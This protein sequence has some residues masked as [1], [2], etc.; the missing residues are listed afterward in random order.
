MFAECVL[1]PDGR[2]AEITVRAKGAYRLACW[3]HGR[4]LLEYAGDGPQ[5]R[6]RAQG[7]E[8]AYRFRSVEQLRYDFERDVADTASSA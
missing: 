5:H 7:R 2:R 6:R 1:L 3:R 8:T 4:L